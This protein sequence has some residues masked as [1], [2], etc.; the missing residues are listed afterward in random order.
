MTRENKLALVVGFALVLFV[1]ILVSDHYNWVRQKPGADLNEPSGTARPKERT[2]ALARGR[3][4][5]KG[6]IANVSDSP[7]KAAPNQPETLVI[8]GNGVSVPPPHQEPSP[9]ELV[10][11]IPHPPAGGNSP[12]G[13]EDPLTRSAPRTYV[14]RKGDTAYG[15]SVAEYGNGAMWQR[16]LDANGIKD[17][18]TIRAGMT[19][20]LPDVAGGRPA[21]ALALDDR[22]GSGRGAGVPV[23]GAGA[24]EEYKVREG[25][26]LS[27]IAERV[28]GSR[29]RWQELFDMN[30]DKLKSPDRVAPGTMLK[31][32]SKV[33]PTRGAQA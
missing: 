1:G 13:I 22:A 7:V 2:I 20:K 28:L 24:R 31:V 33:Q 23:G 9:N 8:G 32:P 5:P 16:I 4:E 26:T 25:D 12:S 11:L 3:E 27:T 21:P 10:R 29:G 14:V 6:I 19:L 18:Q 15:I 30:R 17:A